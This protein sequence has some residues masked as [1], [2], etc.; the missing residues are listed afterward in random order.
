MPIC[1][2]NRESD[3]AKK[4][5]F[6]TKIKV[7]VCGQPNVG[8]STLFNVLTNRK[9]LVANWPGVTVEKYEGFRIHNNILIEFV[10]LPG[11]Y[12]LSSNTIEERITKNYILSYEPDIILVLVDSTI[13][14][15]TFLLAL[16]LLE[17]GSN[18]V[19]VF[20]KID[21]THKKGIHINYNLLEKKLNTPVIPVSAISNQ[22]IDE[23]MDK[24]IDLYNSR[25]KSK[26]LVIN[27]GELEPFIDSIVKVLE[28][29]QSKVVYPIRWI[30]LKILEGDRDIESK[31][32]LIISNED[33]DK[34]K[35]IVNEV[36]IMLKKNPVEIISTRRFQYIYD[37][38]RET[39]V[40]RDIKTSVEPFLFKYIYNPYIGF[41]ISIG[42]LLS[43]FTLAFTINTGFPLNIL[44]N[45][46]GF[47]RLASLIEEYS[48]SS[49]IDKLID[50]VGFI[51][52]KTFGE[53]TYTH[54]VVNGILK[55]FGGI[56]LFLPL[57]MIVSL[58]MALLEDSGLAPRIAVGLHTSLSKIGVSGYAVFPMILSL[59]CNVPGLINTR[60]IPDRLERLRLLLTLS[61]I[62]CQARLIVLLALATTLSKFNSLLLIILGYL[63]GFT[64]FIIIN[65]ILYIIDKKRGYSVSIEILME[66]PSIHKP[67]PKIVWWLTWSNVKH[68]LVKAGVVIFTA[69]VIIWFLT[70]FTTNLSYTNNP[71]ES[72]GS[73]ISRSL[74]FVLKPI[75]VE[76]NYSWIPVF[77]LITGF[78]AKETV[79]STLLITTD[80][81][82]VREAI[83][84]I[85]LTDPQIVSY[86]LFTIL[87][88]PCLA[89][90]AVIHSETRCLKYT[91][92]AILI[93]FITAYT[94]MILSYNLLLLLI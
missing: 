73:Q 15:R 43:I 53:N 67:I 58:T 82:S 5:D 64:V 33:F 49:L 20:T 8:K 4:R 92:L 81:S 76:N 94:I 57:I 3:S 9:V 69:S 77:G 36:E 70:S 35:S 24:I 28:K 41:I 90:L 74:V 51:I 17:L 55:G 40:R 23:L 65:K 86:T 88:I 27:Y 83:D 6:K 39:V 10:D 54:L 63:I 71:N 48:I 79:V 80:S 34:I 7:A 59:G 60:S 85:G 91:L 16:Q 25:R 87:Y 56:V 45:S 18:V 46:I 93:M 32:R 38:F 50:Q 84:K 22:G 42:I 13:P 66:I 78:V 52:Y 44:F 61:F 26:Q 12:G 68:F 37:L 47:R 19:I 89:T 14:E 21:E 1:F 11:V 72:I 30:A 31:L 75:G 29:Y 62:P 2:L